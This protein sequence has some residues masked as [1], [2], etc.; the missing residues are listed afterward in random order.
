MFIIEFTSDQSLMKCAVD[1][2]GIPR[3]TVSECGKPFETRKKA[4]LFA[5]YMRKAYKGCKVKICRIEDADD[6]N[7]YRKVNN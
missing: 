5:F 6:K 2:Y 4:L 7:F 1:T 3:Y